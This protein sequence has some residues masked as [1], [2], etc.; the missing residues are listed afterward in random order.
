[1]LARHHP[2]YALGCACTRGMTEYLLSLCLSLSLSLTVSHCLSVCLS[3]SLSVCLS[4]CL[5]LSRLSLS[6]SLSLPFSLPP[7]LSLPFSLSPFLSL[8]VPLS[9]S[10]SPICRQLRCTLQIRADSFSLKQSARR[11]GK[12]AQPH[13]IA[14]SISSPHGST[15]RPPANVDEKVRAAVMTAERGR[16]RMCSHEAAVTMRM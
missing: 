10:L 6:L 16:A 13:A 9:V 1:V 5:S 7:S 8:S 2:L 3:L 12:L 11:R 14:V 4:L 15:A